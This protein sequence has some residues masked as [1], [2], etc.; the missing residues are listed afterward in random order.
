MAKI[1]EHLLKHLFS[2]SKIEEEKDP[3]RREKLLKDLGKILDYFNELQEV[4]TEDVEPM[5]GGTFLT[6]VFR[7]DGKKL[8]SLAE[9]E[10]QK[11]KIV[12][13]FPSRENKYLKTPPIFD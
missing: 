7:E 10:L 9:K 3:L 13:E 5:T 11:E 8:L 1:D 4:E 6:N 2:L 12:E